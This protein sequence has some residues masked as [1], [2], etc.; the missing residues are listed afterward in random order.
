MHG[1][2]LLSRWRAASKLPG[3]RRVFSRGLGLLV[4]YSGSIKADVLHL[5]PGR[6]EVVMHD[7]RG[8]RNHFRS[9]HAAALFNLAE[10]CAGLALTAQ[11]PK[12]GRLIPTGIDI[13]YD[14]KARGPITATCD[15]PPADFSVPSEVSADVALRDKAG[16]VVS[17]VT[18]RYKIGPTA[19]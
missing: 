3:G 19:R 2:E 5:E 17:R 13:S 7:R 9:L 12:S 6:A 8:L 15:F 10:L 1:E 16:D 11:Q 4:P 18:L 14:K